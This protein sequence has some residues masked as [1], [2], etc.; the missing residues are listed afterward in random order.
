MGEFD[1]DSINSARMPITSSTSNQG[2]KKAKEHNATRPTG[3]SR[4]DR[5]GVFEPGKDG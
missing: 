4:K 2:P 1:I 5:M 3:H